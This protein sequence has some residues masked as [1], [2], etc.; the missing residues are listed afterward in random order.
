MS[1]QNYSSLEDAIKN[2][3]GDNTHIERKTPVSGG[4]INAAFMLTLSDGNKLFLKENSVDNAGFFKAETDGLSAI[5]NTGC[6][7]VPEIYASG[8]YGNRAFILM[9]YSGSGSRTGSFWE[10]FANNLADMHE[11]DTGEYTPGG[12]FGFTSDN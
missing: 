1:S 11:A 3:F 10:D 12:R 5:R 2:H 9:E 6:I 4:D 7:R 8:T